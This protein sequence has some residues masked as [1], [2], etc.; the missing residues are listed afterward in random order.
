M[1]DDSG[2][3]PLHALA[4]SEELMTSGSSIIISLALLLARFD[5]ASKWNYGSLK[6]TLDAVY[7]ARCAH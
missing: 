2:I 4:S 1:S 3:G 5:Y 7:G 6:R